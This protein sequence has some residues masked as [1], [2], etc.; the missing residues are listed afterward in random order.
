VKAA[1]IVATLAIAAFFGL[2]H[3][4]AR[5]EQ[6]LQSKE[7]T[8]DAQELI[9]RE[10]F[11]DMLRIRAPENDYPEKR[12]RSM[13][14]EKKEPAQVTVNIL[15]NTGSTELA[16]DFSVRQIQEAGEA[17]ASEAL[18]GYRFEIAGHTDDT[19]TEADNLKLSQERAEAVKTFL[20]KYYG[21]SPDR[22]VARGY[23]ESL[24]VASND[25]E[26]GRA[27]N[28]RVVFTR[29]DEYK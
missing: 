28:R 23:G 10:Q 7:I 15:F 4:T 8:G 26:E 1:R 16:G 14:A 6:G 22:L 12:I 18:A 21:I 3:P 20:V 17:L 29:I 27:Q 9:S 25:T 24:P 13:E 2:F 11:I 19:G 5:A